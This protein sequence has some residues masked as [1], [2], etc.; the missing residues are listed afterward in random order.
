MTSHEQ[1]V[2]KVVVG[3]PGRLISIQPHYMNVQEVHDMNFQEV[4]RKLMH[5]F[6][7]C[8]SRVRV[9]GSAGIDLT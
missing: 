2:D 7:Y 3:I 6:T 9:I 5:S 4:Q 1:I 8:T